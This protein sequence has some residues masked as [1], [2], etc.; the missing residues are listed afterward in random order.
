[1]A[2]GNRS[3]TGALGIATAGILTGHWLTYLLDVPQGELRASELARTG[4]GY[5]PIA[6]QLATVCM[7]FTLAFLF[8]SRVIRPRACRTPTI[9]ALTLRLAALQ[10]GAFVAMELAERAV[11]GA[12]FADLLHGGLLPL[13]VALQL[14]LAVIGAVLLRVVL[15][16]ADL[17]AATAHARP[18]LPG[19]GFLTALL[20]A[21]R[22][23][24]RI[25]VT[26]GVG[27]RAPPSPV[28]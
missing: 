28:C 25:A 27:V 16:A 3:R 7:A 1:M 10:A 9:A 19:P 24:A 23:R 14:G 2:D 5:L 15:R 22:P 4:H 8:W 18:G 20:P 12:G 13:G 26:G 17:V 11:A 21:P 6:G